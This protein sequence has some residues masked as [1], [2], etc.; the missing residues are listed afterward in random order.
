MC[1]NAGGCGGAGQPA[2]ILSDLEAGDIVVTPPVAGAPVK[3][4]TV[5]ITDY[6]YKFLVFDLNVLAGGTFNIPLNP[7]TT[8]RYMVN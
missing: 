7:S 1:G 3:Y 6:N 4:V 5:Q 8:M 2:K